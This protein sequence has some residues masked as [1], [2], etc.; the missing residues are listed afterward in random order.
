MLQDIPY[1]IGTTKNEELCRTIME[2]KVLK[3]IWGLELG[4]APSLNGFMIH[5]F[6]ACSTTIKYNLCKMLE[7]SKEKSKRRG[8]MNSCS[9]VS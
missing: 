3:A 7:W 9:H 4:K 5:L 6:R 8:N 1:L 2:E